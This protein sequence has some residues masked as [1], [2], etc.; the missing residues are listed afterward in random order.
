MSKSEHITRKVYGSV[1]TLTM[2]RPDQHN[3]F[4]DVIIAELTAAFREFGQNDAV[5]VIVLAAAGRSFSAGA[6]LNW[7]KRMAAYS[8]E[9]NMADAR[10]L[11]DMLGAIALAPKPVIARVQGAAF[12]GGVG[13]VAAC[14]IALG[15][16]RASFSLSEVKLGI[17]PAVISP[18]LLER[19]GPGPSRRFSLTAERFG[20]AEALRVGLL[21]EVH[22]DEEALDAAI[23]DL[24]ALI[25]KNGPAAL[26]ACKELWRAVAA[27]APEDRRDETARR[28]A[29]IRASDEG[30]EGLAAFLEKRTPNWIEE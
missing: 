13:L 8:H 7:M 17:I 29:A 6:D 9:E 1:G 16:E 2:N 27:A 25:L 10:G 24:T 19:I 28:I 30:Q 5:R 20:A 14:D 22:P 11:A 26:A 21:S 4:D 12:G 18:Y 23:A 15:T 3:A